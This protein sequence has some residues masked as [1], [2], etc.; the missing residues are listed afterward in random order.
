[1]FFHENKVILEKIS[2]YYQLEKLVQ[3]FNFEKIE[4]A[5]EEE[6]DKIDVWFDTEN[7]TEH[8]EL[9]SCSKDVAVIAID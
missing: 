8:H 9:E 7:F 4:T 6:E 5:K 2:I 1:M 3:K